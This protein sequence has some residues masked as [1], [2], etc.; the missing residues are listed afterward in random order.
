MPGC[1][2]DYALIMDARKEGSLKR[3]QLEVN[4]TRLLHTIDKLV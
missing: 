3:E 2:K 1:E 4:A